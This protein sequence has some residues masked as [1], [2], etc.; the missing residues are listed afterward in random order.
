MSLEGVSLVFESGPISGAVSNYSQKLILEKAE[1]WDLSRI[2]HS[3]LAMGE[4][5]IARFFTTRPCWAH[6]GG[7][8]GNQRQEPR[9]DRLRYPDP[10]TQALAD[11]GNRT[12]TRPA[13]ILEGSATLS[14]WL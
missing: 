11:A 8:H 9:T 3:Q 10:R 7:N 1:I 14:A 5:L 6:R 13:P 2:S 12:E 4:L